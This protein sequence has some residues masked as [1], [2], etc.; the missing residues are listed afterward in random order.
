MSYGKPSWQAA[1]CAGASCT[2]AQGVL[3]RRTLTSL[4]L[5]AGYALLAYFSVLHTTWPRVSSCRR[6]QL[7]GR[8]PAVCLSRC[9]RRL[10]CS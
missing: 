4:G 1:S 6:R 9:S 7:E 3:P 5:S 8:A 2:V 10:C